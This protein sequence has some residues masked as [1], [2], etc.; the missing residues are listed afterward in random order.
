MRYWPYRQI[1]S[2]T[3]KYTNDRKCKENNRCNIGKKTLNIRGRYIINPQVI[4]WYSPEGRKGRTASEYRHLRPDSCRG[5]TF[6]ER[7]GA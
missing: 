1:E 2:L 4:A 3:L 7:S 6:L 5:L